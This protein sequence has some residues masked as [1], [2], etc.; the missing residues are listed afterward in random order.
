MKNVIKTTRSKFLL[1]FVIAFYFLTTNF[2]CEDDEGCNEA[3]LYSDLLTSLIDVTS[4]LIDIGDEVTIANQIVN[5]GITNTCNVL[6][7]NSIQ[8]RYS[9]DFDYRADAN[10]NWT[11]SAATALITVEELIANASTVKNF[12]FVFQQGGQYRIRGMADVENVVTERNENNNGNEFLQ[13]SLEGDLIITV[14][15]SGK[16]FYNENESIISVDWAKNPDLVSFTSLKIKDI[17]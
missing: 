3:I 11:Q 7:Q 1:V 12:N 14:T 15:N 13:R 16:S 10:S 5:E 17:K 4:G 8:N 9:L 2:S 6:S